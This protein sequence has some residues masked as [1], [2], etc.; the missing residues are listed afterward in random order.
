ML[1]ETMLEEPKT[2]KSPLFGV[3]F[4]LLSLALYVFY[5]KGL[6]A[7]HSVAKADL[8]AKL[9]ELQLLQSKEDAVKNAQTEL[10][11]TS[12]VEQF[13]SIAAVPTNID[14]DEVLKT[15]VETAKTYDIVLKSV[16]FSRSE[17][18]EEGVGVLKI[19]SS[20][21]GSYGDLLSFLGG[22]EGNE[23]LFKVNSISVQINRSSLSD[24]E[25]A[26]F[27]LNIDTF[28]QK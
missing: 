6:A 28:Y 11:L 14:Q 2:K 17:S 1:D 25:R 19:N 18:S 15:V 4:I 8:D 10:D 3:L 21:E 26:N 23:R 5:A 27:S 9:Q 7:Q 12:S 20:F 13:T 16:S 22:L 24:L